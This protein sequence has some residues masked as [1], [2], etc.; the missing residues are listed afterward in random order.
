MRETMTQQVRQTGA[1]RQLSSPPLGPISTRGS[2]TK[3]RHFISAECQLKASSLNLS[4]LSFCLLLLTHLKDQI[5]PRLHHI[6]LDW[7][8]VLCSKWQGCWKHGVLMNSL[9]VTGLA[10]FVWRFWLMKPPD[11]LTKGKD[12]FF[13]VWLALQVQAGFPDQITHKRCHP[14]EVIYFFRK[15]KVQCISYVLKAFHY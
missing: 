14:G 10:F 5:H 8:D 9:H 1:Q 12:V 4:L 7:V 6:L 3:R 13:R 11:A 2:G 15:E